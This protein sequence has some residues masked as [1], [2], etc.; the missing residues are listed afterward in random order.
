M[1]TGFIK[2]KFKKEK[3]IPHHKGLNLLG[4][5]TGFLKNP[6]CFVL[7]VAGEMGDFYKLTIPGYNLYV[8]SNPGLLKHMR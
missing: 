6:Y 3:M 1:S 8:L 4:I 7:D 5:S 2:W